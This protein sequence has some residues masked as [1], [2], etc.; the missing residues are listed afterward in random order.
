MTA[1]PL[2]IVE[3]TVTNIQRI[4]SVHIT[5]NGDP[6]VI[7]GG[8]NGQGKTSV[9]DAIE[10]ALGGGRSISAEPVR[11]GAKQGS[12]VANLGD[13]VVERVIAKDR[14][15]TLTVRD[16]DGNKMRSP[17]AVLDALCSKIAFDPLAFMDL[18]PARQNETLRQLLGLDF[19]KQD[20]ERSR[21]YDKRTETTRDAKAVRAQSEGLVVPPGT[22]AERVVVADVLARL[23]AQSTVEEAR[24][25]H[26]RKRWEAEQAVTQA[27]DALA[28][29][30]TILMNARASL[31]RIEAEVVPEAIEREPIETELASAEAT[32]SNVAK[33]EQRDA[34]EK[35]AGELD[36]E[37]ERLSARIA[38]IDA[39]KA[40]LLASKSFPVP[41]LA[42]GENGPTLDAVPLEQAS[43]AQRLRVSVA[44]GL[45]LNPT[46]KVLLVRDAS[47]LDSKS[48]AL[49]AEMAGEAGAQVWLERVGAGDEHAIVISDGQVANDGKHV[50]A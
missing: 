7:L 49:V 27:K 46:L 16:A 4:R 36:A 45:A 41:G 18:E 38:E 10:M 24:K 15:H 22:P 17:Q 47:L 23:R 9:L 2:K 29:A 26:A 35:K 44:L 37:A 14:T 21:C 20:G 11:K 43:A 48:L 6:T 5:P 31:K 25:L 39:E 19:S 8:D 30:E 33:R 3:L 40:A 32:N 1:K 42:L 12:I 28:R 13:L 50:A 34:L